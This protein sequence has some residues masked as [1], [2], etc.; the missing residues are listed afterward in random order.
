MGFLEDCCVIEE[1]AQHWCVEDQAINECYGDTLKRWSIDF[2]NNILQ[3]LAIAFEGKFCERWEDQ[4]F[5][6]GRILAFSV[7]TTSRGSI[8]NGK[9]SEH[10]Q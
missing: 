2:A 9:M 8:T 4:A 10:G 6:Q 1:V 3:A 7:D 5:Q